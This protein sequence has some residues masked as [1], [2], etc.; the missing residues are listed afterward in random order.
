MCPIPRWVSLKSNDCQRVHEAMK[1][2]YEG[3][4]MLQLPEKGY[5]P[6]MK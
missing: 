1:I 2:R 4:P 3:V 5:V 6:I